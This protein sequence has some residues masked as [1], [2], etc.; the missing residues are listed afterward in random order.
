MSRSSPGST[1]HSS[2]S[3]RWAGFAKSSASC[4]W[5][6]NKANG[7]WSVR[8]DGEINY[9]GFA[10]PNAQELAHQ[11]PEALNIIGIPE[12]GQRPLTVTSAAPL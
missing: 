4:R 9:V 8:V 3:S 10:A 2:S 1:S 5:V 7:E 12:A 11:L 6:E